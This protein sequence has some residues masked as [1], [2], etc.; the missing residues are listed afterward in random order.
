[1]SG[2]RRAHLILGFLTVWLLFAATLAASHRSTVLRWHTIAGGGGP[3]SS[4][5]FTADGTIAQ[6][7]VGRSSS[8]SHRLGGGFWMFEGDSEPSDVHR[9]YVPMLMK[10]AE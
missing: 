9:V 6:P 8:E 1:M 7:I 10:G 2:R 5:S 3:L 4:S